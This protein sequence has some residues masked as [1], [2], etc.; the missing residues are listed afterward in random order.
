MPRVCELPRGRGAVLRARARSRSPT[1]A[2]TRTARRPTAATRTTSSCDEAF[3]LKISPKLNLAA[4]APLLCAGITTYSPLRHWGVGQGRRVGVVGLGG[5]GHMGVKFAARV[6]R[7]GHAVHHVAGQG[8]GRETAR[9]RRGGRLAGRRTKLQKLARQLRLH[10]RHRLG[11]AR[12]Q[13]Y[14]DAAASATARCAGRRAA[15][16]AARRG[17]PADHAAAATSPARSIGGI[18]RDAGDARLSAPSTTSSPT[19]S[20]RRSRR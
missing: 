4:V 14:L 17:V 13:C 5:L 16:A 7:A 19:S 6:R 10:H 20:S 9:R 18:R 1:T 12:S 11:A 15:E 2:P 3:A 8:G